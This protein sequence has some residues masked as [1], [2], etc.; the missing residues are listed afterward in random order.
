MLA[1]DKQLNPTLLSLFTFAT[2]SFFDSST[3]HS[4]STEQIEGLEDYIFWLE[5]DFVDQVFDTDSRLNK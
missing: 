3:T 4:L 1:T 2:D 5:E